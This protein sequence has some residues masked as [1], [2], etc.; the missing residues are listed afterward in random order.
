[1]DNESK[2]LSSENLT[3]RAVDLFNLVRAIALVLGLLAITL[4]R[5]RRPRF[6]ESLSEPRL[7]PARHSGSDP[8]IA[9]EN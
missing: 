9:E 6:G 2:E 3:L 1:M 5:R 7:T 4:W 8:A